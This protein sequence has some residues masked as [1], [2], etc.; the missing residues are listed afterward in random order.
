MSLDPDPDTLPHAGP[1]APRPADLPTANTTSGSLPPPPMAIAAM[2]VRSALWLAVALS[3]G[4]A[5]SLGITRFA[6]A[7]LLPPCA[8]TWGGPMYWPAA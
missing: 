2:S 1:Q 4:A 7:L 5:I 3:M 6:Y 8:K